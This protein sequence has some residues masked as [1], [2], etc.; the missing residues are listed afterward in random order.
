MEEVHAGGVCAVTGLNETFPGEGLGIE[1][2]C[3]LP[4]LIPVL[5]YQVLLTENCNP[6]VLLPKLRQLEEEEPELHIVWKERLREIQIQLMGTVQIEILKS[7]IK[8]RFAVEV[9]FGTGNIVYK[10]TIANTVEGV[11]HF[12]PLRHYAE[13]HLLLEPADPGSGM[14]FAADCSADV[15]DQN[16]QRLVLS[17]LEEKEAHRCAHR[18]NAHRCED[19]AHVRAGTFKAHGGRRF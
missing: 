3:E 5:T 4:V 11:G 8:E 16:W 6:T 7:L 13:V 1:Q 2:A 10:E 17:H 18:L 19:Y 12:E 9:E 14:V 15:L